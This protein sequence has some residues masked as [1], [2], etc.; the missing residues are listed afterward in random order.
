MYL[1]GE[2]AWIQQGMAYQAASCY[3]LSDV[4]YLGSALWEPSQSTPLAVCL[5]AQK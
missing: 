3:A 1:A 5:Q 4:G 2:A